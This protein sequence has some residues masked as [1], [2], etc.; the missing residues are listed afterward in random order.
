MLKMGIGSSS[1]LLESIR[2][3]SELGAPLDKLLATCT[4]NAA[5]LFRFEGRGQLAAENIADV[6]VC[7]KDLVVEATIA[8]GQFLVR[9][10][11]PVVRGV[12]EDR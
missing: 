5:S 1:T 3:A 9:D 11:E 8:Q 4:L 10:S 7:S 12:F 6:V 2:D